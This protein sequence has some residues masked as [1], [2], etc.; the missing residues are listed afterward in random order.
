M[1][2]L[3][4]MADDTPTQPKKCGG[5]F[6]RLYREAYTGG[7]GDVNFKTRFRPQKKLS[8]EG[9][10][11]C[12]HLTCEDMDILFEQFLDN[13]CDVNP[14]AKNGTLY[15]LKVT[16]I[17]TDWET[18]YVDDYDLEFVEVKNVQSN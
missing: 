18:G 3:K 1:T 14:N 13:R 2:E 12:L 5:M 17:S 11:V 7:A 10:G 8:C 15:Q 16:N 4:I 9:C 6:Y